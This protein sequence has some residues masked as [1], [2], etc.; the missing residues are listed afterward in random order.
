MYIGGTHHGSIQT[1]ER[2]PI[3]R[4]GSPLQGKFIGIW[5]KL[6]IQVGTP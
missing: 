6:P 4:H 3:P 1:I 2:L 5:K